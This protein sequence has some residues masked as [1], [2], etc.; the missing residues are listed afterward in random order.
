MS[1]FGLGAPRD[2]ACLCGSGQPYASCCRPLHD[3]KREA[4]SAEELM[5]SRYVAFAKGL[6]PYLVRSWHP[7]TRPADV[8]GDAKIAWVGLE[9]LDSEAGGADDDD[10]TVTF[11]ASY[12]A[13]TDGFEGEI[14]EHSRFTRHRGRWTYVDGDRRT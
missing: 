7:T 14:L 6:R 3:G 5:R 2:A 12:R 8:I 4:T 9:I 10:G 13:T 11:R 1:G